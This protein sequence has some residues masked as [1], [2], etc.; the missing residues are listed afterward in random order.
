[1][2]PHKVLRNRNLTHRPSSQA[3]LPTRPCI[4]IGRGLCDSKGGGVDFSVTDCFVT[5][6]RDM[7]ALLPTR[8]SLV[9]SMSRP[10]SPFPSN[11]KEDSQIEQTQALVYL[12][13]SKRL[14]WSSMANIRWSSILLANLVLSLFIDFLMRIFRSDYRWAQPL[15]C[16]R[17]CVDLWPH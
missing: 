1:M 8:R 5:Q 7:F 16:H 10:S 2:F 12:S 14:Y 9:D 15:Q 4:F 13:K 11:S 3:P 17:S 6:K